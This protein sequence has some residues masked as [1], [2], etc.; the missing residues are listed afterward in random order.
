MISGA[1]RVLRRLAPLPAG[2]LSLL[3]LLAVGLSCFGSEPEGSGPESKSARVTI[4]L[5]GVRVPSFFGLGIQWDPYSY[6]PRPEAWQLTLKRLDYARPAFFRVMLG[7]RDYCLGFDRTDNAPRYVWQEGEEAVQKRLGSLLKILDYAQSRNIDVLLGEWS[8][9]GR[10]ADGPNERIERPDDPRWARLIADFVTWL[11]TQRKYSVIRMYNMMNEPNGGW[12]WRG[13]RVDYSA[14]ASGIRNLRKEFDAH[15]LKDLPIV[16]P[17]NS[18]SWDWADRVSREMPECIGAW[19]MHWYAHDREVLGGEIERLLADKRRVILAN[20]PNAPSKRLFL[21]ESG[22]LDGKCNGDQQPRVKSFE[23]G[24]M[25]ADYVAQ[26]AQA[27]WMGACAWDLDDAMHTVRGHPQV[28]TELTLKVWGFWNSQGTAMGHPEDE[29]IRP[30]FYTWSLMSRLFPRDAR[31]LATSPTGLAHLRVLAGLTGGG[32]KLSVM[33]VNNADEAR[34]VEVFVPGA[35]ARTLR[36]YR[37]FENERP[38]DEEGFPVSKVTV[39]KADLDQ[40]LH[41]TLN[42]RG[43]VFLTEP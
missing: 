26:V 14:W 20:D 3:L 18:G 2:E 17:D 21:A 19:E 29:N 10:L 1:G 11:R 39:A 16:G 38:T 33:L 35:G 5:G 24:V 30:W 25:M 40:G 34:T 8:P 43:V 9:P 12:M 28:P 6:P 37:Y 7:A 22:L 42:G 27:G 31:I 32:H 15:G 13:G 23:Y 41:L 4:S 36:E